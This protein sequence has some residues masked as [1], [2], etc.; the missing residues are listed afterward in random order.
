MKEYIIEIKVVSELDRGGGS[1]TCPRIYS[2]AGMY[3]LRTWCPLP[4]ETYPIAYLLVTGTQHCLSLQVQ[5][6]AASPVTDQPSN[7][8]YLVPYLCRQAAHKL[9]LEQVWGIGWLTHELALLSMGWV[10]RIPCYVI[11]C[12]WEKCQAQKRVEGCPGFVQ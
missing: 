5:S 4:Q 10:A 3:N 11:V 12:A 7:A 2:G 9:G 1:Q 6:K 8:A